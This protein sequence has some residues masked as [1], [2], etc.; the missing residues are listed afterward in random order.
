VGSF[1]A[2]AGVLCAVVTGKAS[3][4]SQQMASITA[5]PMRA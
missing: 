2:V 1:Q 3:V 4:T 5:D